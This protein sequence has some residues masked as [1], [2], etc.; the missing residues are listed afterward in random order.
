MGRLAV[1]KLEEMNSRVLA[2]DP[3]EYTLGHMDIKKAKDESDLQ[4]VT[5]ADESEQPIHNEAD[6]AGTL[7]FA[8]LA[9]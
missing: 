7:E 9:V 1:Q 3:D 5:E 2:W 6:D 4:Q 8:R